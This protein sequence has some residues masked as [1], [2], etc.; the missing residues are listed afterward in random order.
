MFLLLNVPFNEKEEVKKMGAKWNNE[1]KKWYVT[2]KNEY[3]KFQRWFSNPYNN[4]IVLDHIYIVV[5]TQRCFKCGK[6]TTVVSL[7]TDS[8]VTIDDEQFDLCEEDIDFIQLHEIKSERLLQHLNQKYKFY[9]DYSY[10]TKTHYLANHCDWCGVLQG[11]WFLY[12]EPDSPFFMTSEE[13]AKALSIF[14]VTLPHD[15]DICANVGWCSGN[16]MIKE[17]AEI[18]ELDLEI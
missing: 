3:Y 5:A 6:I 10:T 8:Y 14:K 4:I 1:I 11:N 7:A 16:Y 17:F 13:K 12:S 2:D 15:I 9:K 18:K